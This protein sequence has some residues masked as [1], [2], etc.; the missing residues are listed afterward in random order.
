MDGRD[1]VKLA[2]L[3]RRERRPRRRTVLIVY[4]EPHRLC[5][6]NGLIMCNIEGVAL[7]WLTRARRRGTERRHEIATCRSLRLV[8]RKQLSITTFSFSYFH[9]YFGDSAFIQV[10]LGCLQRNQE[11]I[12]PYSLPLAKRRVVQIYIRGINL[13]S[14]VDSGLS[15]R[16]N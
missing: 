4:C 1:G 10:F 15:S 2:H 16:P 12:L 7:Q 8:I 9:S 5:I 14:S 11:D 6:S 3:G 13:F